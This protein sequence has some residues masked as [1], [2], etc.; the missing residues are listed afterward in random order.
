MKPNLLPAEIFRASWPLIPLHFYSTKPLPAHSSVRRRWA[1]SFVFRPPNFRDKWSASSRIFIFSRC[2]IKSARW[3]WA[4]CQDPAGT[5]CMASI[6][7]V[8]A[9][10]PQTCQKPSPISPKCTNNSIASI[11]SSLISKDFAKL[12]LVATALASPVAFYAMQKWLQ[13]FA[14]RIEI[15]WLIFVAAGVLTAVIALLT[16]SYQALKAAL[17]NPVEALRYE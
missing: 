12:V 11:Q 8:C 10:V 15:G 6:I 7:S 5:H 3:S 4:L 14:Y 2:T 9:S 1:N 17:G 13:S 16:I